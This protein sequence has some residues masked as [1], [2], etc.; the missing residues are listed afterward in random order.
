MDDDGED[1]FDLATVFGN[2]GA[3]Q[4]PEE[5][6]GDGIVLQKSVAGGRRPGDRAE[7]KKCRICEEAMSMP[8]SSWC[9]ECKPHYDSAQK[10]A[11]SQGKDAEKFFKDLTSRPFEFKNYM[12]RF[13]KECPAVGR[14]SKR[15]SFDTLAYKRSLVTKQETTD[16]RR[17]A[18]LTQAEFFEMLKS[19]DPDISPSVQL[20]KWDGYYAIESMRATPCPYTG[21]ERIKLLVSE[22]TDFNDIVS[23]EQCAERSSRAIKNPSEE[24]VGDI[25]SATMMHNKSYFKDNLAKLAPNASL[26]TMLLD[27]RLDSLFSDRDPSSLAPSPMKGSSSHSLGGDKERDDE[28][29]TKKRKG[30][31]MDVAISN[32]QMALST[33]VQELHG[34]AKSSASQAVATLK[35]L[36]EEEKEKVKLL[37]PAA[38]ER[39]KAVELFAKKD[40]TGKNINTLAQSFEQHKKDMQTCSPCDGFA[41]LK[42]LEMIMKD[43]A[44]LSVGLKNSEDPEKELKERAKN[45]NNHLSIGK[46]LIGSLVRAAKKISDTKKSWKTMEDA[47]LKKEEIKRKVEETKSVKK[48]DQQVKKVKKARFELFSWLMNSHGADGC[49]KMKVI[50]SDDWETLDLQDFQLS[51]CIKGVTALRDNMH[52]RVSKAMGLFKNGFPKSAVCQRD[53]RAQAAL[54]TNLVRDSL[55]QYAKAVSLT[56]LDLSKLPVKVV[57]YINSTHMFGYELGNEFV[58]IDACCGSIGTFKGCVEGRFLL[59]AAPVSALAK[60][61]ATFQDT[62][63]HL[64]DITQQDAKGLCQSGKG[65][66]YYAEVCPGDLVWIPAGCILAEK[67]LSFTYGFR[68][69]M[70]YKCSKAGLQNIK[71]MLGFAG[72]LGQQEQDLISHLSALWGQVI[73]EAGGLVGIDCSLLIISVCLL[74]LSWLFALTLLWEAAAP[75]E[76]NLS[77]ANQRQDEVQE[78]PQE[79][80][81]EQPLAEA[82]GGKGVE[83][84]LAAK[85]AVN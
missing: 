16:G 44:H 59:A 46:A 52:E 56:D 65:K 36:T 27:T 69:G 26:S 40:T 15:L 55:L 85:Y 58:G 67:A 76:S 33:K 14:G 19:K 41:N 47:R 70:I 68:T 25:E 74:N 2:Q 34:D 61:G 5:D 31:D 82:E 63:N 12:T 29:R 8:R 43:I 30:M 48:E 77:D 23:R 10:Q 73:E 62:I 54:S 71:E 72:Q 49:E 37:E 39:C 9:K 1:I 7:D 57:D 66:I 22:Y 6:Q 11:K 38:Q 28:K 3:R 53:G 83:S 64:K 75:G 17:A 24:V 60:R 20:E 18:P 32:F 13:I 50:S 78:E 45:I 4:D 80:E 21:K 51:L 42:C 35:A 84:E 79:V 81:A